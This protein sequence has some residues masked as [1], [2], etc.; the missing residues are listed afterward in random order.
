MVVVLQLI[1]LLCLCQVPIDIS[2]TQYLMLEMN[3]VYMIA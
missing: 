2:D 3:C 1:S